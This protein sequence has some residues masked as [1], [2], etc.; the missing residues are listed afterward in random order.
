MRSLSCFRPGSGLAHWPVG[1]FHAVIMA[2]EIGMNKVSAMAAA[3]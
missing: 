1:R 3:S 2:C